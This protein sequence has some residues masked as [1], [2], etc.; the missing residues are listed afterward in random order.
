MATV[1]PRGDQPGHAGPG[2]KPKGVSRDYHPHV[3]L[4]RC[5]GHHA[6]QVLESRYNLIVKTLPVAEWVDT[7]ITGLTSTPITLTNS[8]AQSYGPG[9]HNFTEDFIF[10]LRPDLSV[11]PAQKAELNA[12]NI[13]LIHVFHNQM[14]FGVPGRSGDK[15]TILGLD[16]SF[17][18][19]SQATLQDIHLNVGKNKVLV[20][21]GIDADG[22]NY[23]FSNPV[24]QITGGGTLTNQGPQWTLTADQPG[25]WELDVYGPG[26]ARNHRQGHDPGRLR[27][28]GRQR[29]AADHRDRRR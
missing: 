6:V 2:S 16:G 14:D 18:V 3:Y 22:K 26:E 29:H 15:L 7:V 10:E 27:R 24:W 13:R 4:W 5:S 8:F 11:T 9:H 12:K 20:A 17:R 21:M 1:R 25:K 28:A 19:A 23:T